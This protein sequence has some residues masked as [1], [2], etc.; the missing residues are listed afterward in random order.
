MLATAGR[1]YVNR[2]LQAEV[3]TRFR[4]TEIPKDDKIRH[5]VA[6]T[7]VAIAAQLLHQ[8]TEQVALEHLYV[9]RTLRGIGAPIEF[10]G[11]SQRV[12][13]DTWFCVRADRGG[14]VWRYPFIVEV[15]LHS[16]RQKA[17]RA[18]V[19]A[20]LAWAENAQYQKL[21]SVRSGTFTVVSPG[22]CRHAEVLRIWTEGELQEIGRERAGARWLFT[23]NNPAITPARRFFAARIWRAAFGDAPIAALP[24]E[25]VDA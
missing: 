12:T 8:P 13:P 20:L 9:E 23:G 17:W 7:D 4:P 11:K 3:P 14:R 16:E 1:A 19:R 22:D 25:V 10:E 6:A 15:D 2:H 21:F 18:K 5:V 24:L